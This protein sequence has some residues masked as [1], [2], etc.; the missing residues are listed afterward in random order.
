MRHP[1]QPKH[2]HLNL[3]PPRGKRFGRACWRVMQR[4]PCAGM[5]GEL[6]GYGSG[7]SWD[8]GGRATGR[9]P[10]Q[11]VGLRSARNGRRGGRVVL[12]LPIR[13]E[14]GRDEKLSKDELFVVVVR[15]KT[16]I[17]LWLRRRDADILALRPKIE[18]LPCGTSGQNHHVCGLWNTICLHCG[19]AR[20]FCV[21]R[22]HERAQAVRELPFGAESPA[23]RRRVPARAVR[24]HLR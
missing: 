19:R 12:G 5:E 18:E 14:I 15:L 4:S 2:P 9:S 8:G 24:S 11:V 23:R 1:S 13:G 6:G 7:D 20:V 3:P 16:C 17:M 10:L 21:E 22:V